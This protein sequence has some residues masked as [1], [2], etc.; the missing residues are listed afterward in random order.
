M[1]RGL[2]PGEGDRQGMAARHGGC[3]PSPRSVLTSDT[4][5]AGVDD[6]HARASDVAAASAAELRAPGSR[7]EAGG[8]YKARLPV[9][10]RPGG[11][12]ARDKRARR[13]NSVLSCRP[14][15][16]CSLLRKCIPCATNSLMG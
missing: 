15:H 8:L 13:C 9:V 12:Y 6:V 11:K 1:W 14:G 3:T 4:S 7:Q 2:G 10:S 16:G 5:D